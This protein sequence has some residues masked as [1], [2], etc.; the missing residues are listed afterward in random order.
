MSKFL[1]SISI[2][3]VATLLAMPAAAQTFG[4]GRAALPEEIAA[5]N[6]DIHPDG[7]G[8]PDGQGD[9]IEGLSLIHI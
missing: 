7:T 5:W 1:K 9:A 2:G 6:L 8:L 4:L 3:A